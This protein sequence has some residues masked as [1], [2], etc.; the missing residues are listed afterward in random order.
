MEIIKVRSKRERK[1]FVDLPLKMY[2][3]NEYFVPPL[4]A[5]EMAVFTNKNIYS[6]TCESEFFL[7][8]KD[9]EVVGRIQGIIQRAHNEIS[10]DKRVRFTRFDA[11]DDQEV[12]N[13]LF[14]ALEDWAK[15]KG[16]NIVCGP[17]GYSDLE[18]EGLLI[19]GFEYL[20]TFE[21]QYNYPYYA[22]LVDNCG[23]EKEVDW[24]ESRLYKPNETSAKIGRVA[25][26]TLK[27]NKLHIGGKNLS[28]KQFISKYKDGIFDCIDICYQELYG[29]VP[30]TEEMKK[31]IIDQFMLLIDKKFIQVV[32]D[33][34]EKVVAFGLCFPA[35]G[36][37]LQKS[38]GKLTLPT[39]IRLLKI[40]KRPKALDL[41]LIGVLPEYQAKGV[42]AAILQY[43]VEMFDDDNIEYCETNLNLEN[44]VKVQQQWK[45]FDNIQHKRRRSYIK[46]L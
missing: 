23:Y 19:D 40:I 15:E 24:V 44:N 43:L 17:L 37:S 7:A 2:K 20:S 30:F 16:M 45:Y 9:G 36:E 26:K 10:G 33:E 46:N 34:N 4:Y 11:I 29:V 25:E 1:Q 14:G 13:A 21:E 22:K 27:L 31:Q 18:R 5:D 41:G 28:K 42:N 8:V 12:A 32:C 3:N 35:I 38:G 39:L 6:K